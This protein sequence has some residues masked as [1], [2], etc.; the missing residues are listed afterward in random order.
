MR[1]GPIV[2]ENFLHESSMRYYVTVAFRQGYGQ[3]FDAPY[4]ALEYAE[5]QMHKLLA[6]HAELEQED[7]EGI[8]CVPEGMQQIWRFDYE[9]GRPAWVR[10]GEEFTSMQSRLGLFR[11]GASWSIA[12]KSQAK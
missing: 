8:F 4:T 1:T 7:F 10:V 9:H 2:V 11:Q 3:T 6:E 5:D 12:L